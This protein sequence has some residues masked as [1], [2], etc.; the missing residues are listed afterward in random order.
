MFT[1]SV[2]M[3]I[4]V[5]RG[6]WLTRNTSATGSA[7]GPPQVFSGSDINGEQCLSYSS[8]GMKRQRVL[9]TGD[10]IADHSNS[11]MVPMTMEEAP[12][13]GT[14]EFFS[15]TESCECRSVL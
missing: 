8:E 3:S 12:A 14:L 15:S 9:L 5:V 7:V 13:S 6:N 11:N 1:N 2:S 4:D 10:C